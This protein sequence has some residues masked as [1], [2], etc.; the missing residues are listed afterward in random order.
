MREVICTSKFN[1]IPSQKY[2]FL[3]LLRGK[4]AFVELRSRALHLMSHAQKAAHILLNA[5]MS[6]ITKTSE[7]L[8][9]GALQYKFSKMHPEKRLSR[10]RTERFQ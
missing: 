5:Q 9:I 8:I 6:K 3:P 4:K 1:L 10:T 2:F 7:R